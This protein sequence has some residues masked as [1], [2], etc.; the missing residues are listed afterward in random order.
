MIQERQEENVKEVKGDIIHDLKE[1]E[2]ITKKI[3]KENKCIIINLLYKASVDSCYDFF[4][5]KKIKIFI[6]F[7]T[8]LVV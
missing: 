4:G 1:I 2:M 3:N 5:P 6:Q 7:G 8:T